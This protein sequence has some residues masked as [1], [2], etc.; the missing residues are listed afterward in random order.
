VE[1]TDRAL[2][3]MARAPVPGA[4]KTRLAAALGD[5]QT[6]A[7]YGCF[8]RD[9]MEKLQTLSD[10][11]VIVYHAPC[12][13]VEA[14]LLGDLLPPGTPLRPQRGAAFGDR[15]RVAL[16][17]CDG[18]DRRILIGTDSPSLPPRFVHDAFQ[19]LERCDVVLGPAT[20]G[21]Y[22]LLG[23]QRAH[24]ELFQDIDWSTSA[25]L[26]QTAARCRQARLR[27]ALLPPWYDVDEIDDLNF[28]LGHTRALAQAG[29]E[30][31]CRHT[32]EM[33]NG[34]L[35]GRLAGLSR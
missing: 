18:F 9:T 19:A 4:V 31:P 10:A 21:G 22:Y 15:M 23:V 11:Q 35:A 3:V 7:L 34:P 28:L 12:R 20:D 24:P 16:E 25:V 14:S 32:C 5:R 6:A 17:E 13:P 27:L 8:V 1:K 30:C 29:Q 2:I 33:L 26:A